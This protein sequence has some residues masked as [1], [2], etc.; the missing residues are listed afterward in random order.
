METDAHPDSPSP[1]PTPE[2]ARVALRAAEQ[3]RSSIETI[4]VP[5][6]YF[7]ALALLVAVLALGQLLPG[8]ATVV[9]TLVALAGVGGLVRVYVNKVGVRAQLGRADARLVWPPT[10]G[11][12]LTFAAAAV[13]DVA[14]GQTYWWVAAAAIGALIIAASGALFRRRARRS[15]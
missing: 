10:I 2:E 12:F 13:L 7:P 8:P 3:A 6:W 9:V 4:P 15:A 1:R 11:I 5:G 14:Y